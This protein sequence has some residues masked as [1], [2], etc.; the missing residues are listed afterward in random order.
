MVL[1]GI[2]DEILQDLRER[3]AA[4]R[5]PQQRRI[6]V[7]GERGRQL[8]R[9]RDFRDEA[10]R[11]QRRTRD[12]VESAGARIQQDIVEQ[13][14]HAPRAA[15][16]L[17]Q[18]LT[19]RPADGR[20]VLQDEFGE[21][22]DPAQG[23]PQI[24]RGHVD[25]LVELPVDAV[26]VVQI[27]PF[28]RLQGAGGR[29][30]RF[31]AR[32]HV[33]GDVP[34]RDQELEGIVA[35]YRRDAEL[36]P[37]APHGAVA[38]VVHFEQ[39]LMI[40]EESFKCRR[41]EGSLGRTPFRRAPAHVEVVDTASAERGDAAIG[42]G[43]TTPNGVDRGNRSMAIERRDM[44]GQRIERATQEVPAAADRAPRIA[45]IERPRRD[46]VDAVHDRVNVLPIAAAL[47][48]RGATCDRFKHTVKSIGV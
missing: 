23:R 2:A 35:A 26:D 30:R 22:G 48:L 24:V 8:E 3:H 15:L 16:D 20:I 11:R 7:Q 13:V 37:L 45:R 1:D 33:A 39:V 46:F 44:Q 18:S 41:D 40:G 9:R 27:P 4:H 17:Q 31:G 47:R 43:I 38:G 19:R 42:L 6:E 10:A 21:R 32:E 28:G 25:D 12:G 34:M 5:R 14:R 29:Q 36:K